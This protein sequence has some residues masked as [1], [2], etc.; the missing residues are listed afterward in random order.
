[1]S[2]IRFPEDLDGSSDPWINFSTQRPQYTRRTGSTRQIRIDDGPGSN[3]PGPPGTRAPAAASSVS[4]YFPTGHT[5]ND[6]LGYDSQEEGIAGALISQFLSSGSGPQDITTNDIDEIATGVGVRSLSAFPGGAVFSRNRGRVANPRE[7]MM[8]KSPSIREFSFAFTF[9]PQSEKEAGSLPG[10]IKFFR[11]AAYPRE[12]PTRTEYIFPD[13][14]KIAY[15]NAGG[16]G[17][18]RIPEVACTSINVT[19]N[20]NSISF[21]RNNGMP[22]Q[23]TLELSFTELKPI[24]RRLV[25]EG[26]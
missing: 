20:P 6:S 19:Y 1:M 24:A 2:D 12:S 3:T 14:F 10:I 16:G 11:Q 7:F 4:L 13:T 9:I 8:F 5:I 22:V 23:T 15:Q 25:N 21:F 17:I 18:I 26:F